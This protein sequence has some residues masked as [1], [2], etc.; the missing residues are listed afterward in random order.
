MFKEV[1]KKRFSEANAVIGACAPSLH[2]EKERITAVLLANILGGPAT[3]SLLNASLREKHGWVYAVECSYTQYSDTGIMAISLGCDKANL[4]RCMEEVDRILD[5][6]CNE[7]LPEEK[8]KAAR[9][10]LLGQLAISS[11]GGEAQVLS[12]GKSMMAF[13]RIA[14]DEDNR[15]KIESVSAEDIR[16]MARRVF[17]DKN[18]LI[19]R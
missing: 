10:Q 16:S 9:K 15:S 13:G 19:Y 12:M 3:N 18:I 7:L 4:D 5:N 14:S 6:L 11:D 2:E 17:L 8:M 1:L